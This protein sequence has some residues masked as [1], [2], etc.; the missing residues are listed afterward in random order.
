MTSL[1]S[2]VNSVTKL[3]F[4]VDSILGN[5]DSHHSS[6]PVTEVSRSQEPPCAGCVAALYRCCR[7]EP[8]LLQLPLPLPYTHLHPA[9]RPT[10]VYRLPLPSSSPPQ[11]SSAPRCDVT[12]SGKRKRSWSRAVFS[13]LQRKGLER[14]FQ[15]QK[16]ITKPDR[17]QLAATLGLTDAQVKVWFQNRRMKWRHTKEGRGGIAGTTGLPGRDPDSTNDD[18]EDID[19]DTLSD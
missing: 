8:P 1:N 9:L 16:Y 7:D 18:N 15:I 4:S 6:T 17:R 10:T 13:N 3:K 11:P 12:S 5:N 19:V 2:D 14:R